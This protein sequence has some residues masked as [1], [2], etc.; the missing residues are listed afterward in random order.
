MANYDVLVIGA[1]PAGYVAAIRAAQLG[2]KVAVVDKEFLGGVCLNVGCIPSKALL[3]NAEVA[4]TLRTKGEEFGF[5]FSNL[6][7]DYAS[8]VKRSRKVSERLGGGGGYLVKK[9]QNDVHKGTA[10]L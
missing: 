10:T 3:K 8:A 1:G 4:H 2:N 6:K 9:K 5:S 7:L